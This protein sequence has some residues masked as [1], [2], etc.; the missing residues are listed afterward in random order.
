MRDPDLR[1][2]FT[3]LAIPPAWQ[4]VWIC[5]DPATR[6]FNEMGPAATP[7]EAERNVVQVIKNVAEKLGNTPAVCRQHYVHPAIVEI[8]LDGQLSQIYADT[9]KA[10][11]KAPMELGEDEAVV[12]A[13]LSRQGDSETS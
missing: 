10:I 6:L 13:I 11:Q 3:T 5:A 8:Y 12:H 7:K 2:R 4:A 9:A 1:Q